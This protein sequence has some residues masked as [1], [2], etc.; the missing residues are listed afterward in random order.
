[1]ARWVSGDSVRGGGD[2]VVE[3]V[4]LEFNVLNT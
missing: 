3:V 1:V 4:V 2:S